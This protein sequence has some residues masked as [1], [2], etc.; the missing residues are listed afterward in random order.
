PLKKQLLTALGPI[1]N[2]SRDISGTNLVARHGSFG[3]LSLFSPANDTMAPP[4]RTW[5]RRWGWAIGKTVLALAILAGVGWR[6][7][8]DLREPGLAR[9]EFHWPWL[10]LSAGLY[11]IALGF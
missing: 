4:M 8:K 7:Y 3:A 9:L 10:L 5:I 11:I 1:L 2:P 6:F